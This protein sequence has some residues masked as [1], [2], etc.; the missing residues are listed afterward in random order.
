MVVQVSIQTKDQADI[1][2]YSENF[3]GNF[4][5]IDQNFI[6]KNNY[7]QQVFKEKL[8]GYLRLK[9]SILL[10]FAI[11]VVNN[12]FFDKEFSFIEWWKMKETEIRMLKENSRL[13]ECYSDEILE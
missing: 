2:E 3:H 10:N 7:T 6:I 4:F 12:S 1:K 9:G 11:E 5:Y 8:G 13:S